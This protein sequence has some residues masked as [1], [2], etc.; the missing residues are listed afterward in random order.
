PVRPRKRTGV[1]ECLLSPPEGRKGGVGGQWT[2]TVCVFVLLAVFGSASAA[3]T[4]VVSMMLPAAPVV[5]VMLMVTVALGLTVPRVQVTRL[6]P[7][8]GAAHVPWLAVAPVKVSLEDSWSVSTTLWATAGPP[9]VTVMP[10]VNAE[11]GR[12]RPGGA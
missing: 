11:F 8:A 3:L 6:V 7:T 1:S 10:Y 2:R 12:A 4:P 9:L 5:T